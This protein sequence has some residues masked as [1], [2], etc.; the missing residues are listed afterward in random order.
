MHR[1]CVRPTVEHLGRVHVG[2]ARL[3]PPLGPHSWVPHLLQPLQV[4]G[5]MLGSGTPQHR[6][7]AWIFEWGGFV[8][9]WS[10]LLRGSARRRSFYLS[11]WGCSSVSPAFGVWL[12]TSIVWMEK[13]TH[14]RPERTRGARGTRAHPQSRVRDVGW[15]PVRLP[16]RLPV[17]VLCALL[18]VATGAGAAFESHIKNEKSF[19]NSFWVF[20]VFGLTPRAIR[21]PTRASRLPLV[22][23]LT[24]QVFH[25]SGAKRAQRRHR[26]RPP[27][28]RPAGIRDRS[29]TAG[30]L[31]PG[32]T[33]AH[34]CRLIACV[35]GPARPTGP[36]V[37]DGAQAR[38]AALEW[39]AHAHSQAGACYARRRTVGRLRRARQR[40]LQGRLL[41]C[42][43]QAGS[44]LRGAPHGVAGPHKF[45]VN[46]T[47]ARAYLYATH[48][49]LHLDHEQD[50]VVTCD[51]WLQ[52]LAALAT[53]DDGVD[54]AFLGARRPGGRGGDGA[55]LHNTNYTT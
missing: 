38:I 33:A 25:A 54:G 26:G 1:H 4:H 17:E 50:L 14:R 11:S 23:P 15:L 29:V 19:S 48:G 24:H 32:T 30:A 43:P 5:Q 27:S 55:M 13:M 12:P 52:A 39:A 31:S 46:L 40:E 34:G 47:C 3:K 21:I 53:W 49:E 20:W 37:Q 2:F 7:A 45:S 41:E 10:D 18:C 44:S 8:P 16:D 22:L 36:T 42:L 6:R 51:M 9:I 28:R 35:C